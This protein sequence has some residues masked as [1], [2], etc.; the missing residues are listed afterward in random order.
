MQQSDSVKQPYETTDG[1]AVSMYCEEGLKWPYACFATPT[2]VYGL[3]LRGVSDEGWALFI[4]VSL[5]RLGTRE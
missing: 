5:E 3:L 1:P 4:L 2:S